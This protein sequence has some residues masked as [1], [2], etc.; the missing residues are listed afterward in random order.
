MKTHDILK[1]NNDIEKLINDAKDSIEEYFA[2]K[3]NSIESKDYDLSLNQFI[4]KS[5]HLKWSPL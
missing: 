5:C 1:K 4:F 2:K 3:N